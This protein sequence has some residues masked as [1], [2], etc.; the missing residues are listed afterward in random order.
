VNKL[1]DKVLFTGYID[2]SGD[3]RISLYDTEISTGLEDKT[4]EGIIGVI[5]AG[6]EKE[7]YQY[8]D[9][10]D[11]LEADKILKALKNGLKHLKEDY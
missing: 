4:W 11:R 8:F 5:E 9:K 10:E 3:L 6:K 7:N 2:E 1:K